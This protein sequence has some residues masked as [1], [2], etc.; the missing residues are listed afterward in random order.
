MI[1]SFWGYPIGSIA[2]AHTRQALFTKL[3][4]FPQ[5]TLGIIQV[6]D[7]WMLSYIGE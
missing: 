4:G 5:K 1:G 3:L 2:I 6:R 7:K